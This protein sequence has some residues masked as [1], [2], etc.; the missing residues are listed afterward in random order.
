MKHSIL[1]FSICSLLFIMTSC[2]QKQQTNEP[3]IS[4]TGN[5]ERP[6]WTPIE[7]HDLTSSMILIVEVNLSLNPD[8]AS[9]GANK[10]VNENDVLAAFSGDLCLGVAKLI[11]G[12]FFLYISAPLTENNA[13][14][15][16][17]IT[18]RYY[19]AE[20]KNIFTSA[21]SVTFV[22]DTSLGTVGQPYSPLFVIE[23]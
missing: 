6:S 10:G 2:E 22:N 21:E 8:Y 4:L 16:N 15:N 20:L 23:K 11:D 3:V 9:L 5:V 19:S 18:L 7:N 12:L 17:Q 14:F 13:E 1:L